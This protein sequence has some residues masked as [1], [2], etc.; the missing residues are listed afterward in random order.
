MVCLFSRKTWFKKRHFSD[1]DGDNP[2]T[3]FLRLSNGLLI[4]L[5]SKDTISMKENSVTSVSGLS[6]EGVI[7]ILLVRALAKI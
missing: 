6:N 2:D 1:T 4:E 7:R 3:R 5:N